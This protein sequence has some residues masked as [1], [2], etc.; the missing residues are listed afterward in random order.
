[1]YSVYGVCRGESGE[2]V[3]SGVGVI[4]WGC[5]GRKRAIKMNRTHIHTQREKA[6]VRD[7]DIYGGEAYT[8]ETTDLRRTL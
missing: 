2:S 4:E 1:M 6:R 7:I 8:V 3:Y 5:E